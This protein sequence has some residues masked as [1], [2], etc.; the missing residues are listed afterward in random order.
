MRH[1]TCVTHMPWCMS[2]SLTRSG[3][4]NDPG[5]PGACATRNFTYMG[6]GPNRKLF[7][8]CQC[9]FQLTAT[10]LSVNGL[11]QCQIAVVIPTTGSSIIRCHV[12][13]LSQKSQLWT[14]FINASHTSVVGTEYFARRRL[15]FLWIACDQGKYMRSH[16]E[17]NKLR[18]L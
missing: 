4:E 5:F 6:R 7:S 17:I 14:I 11:R 13:Q 15:L 3:G 8:Q 12:Y 1:G 16:V 2:G 18:R 9:S 10:L